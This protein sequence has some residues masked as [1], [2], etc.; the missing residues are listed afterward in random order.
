MAYNGIEPSVANVESGG[1]RFIREAYLVTKAR[2]S[3]AVAA[4]LAFV[5]SDQGA[6]V[7]KANDAIPV[8]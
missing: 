7:L 4:F 8:R 3:A 5:G 2:P 6:A 1:Y